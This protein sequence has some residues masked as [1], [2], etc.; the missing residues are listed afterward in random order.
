[1]YLIPAH[2]IYLKADEDEYFNPDYTEVDRVLAE[3]IA[4]AD[5]DIEGSIEYKHYLVKWCALPYEDSTW[6]LQADVNAA[7]IEAFKKFTEPP[8]D[9]ERNVSI[10]IQGMLYKFFARAISGSPIFFA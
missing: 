6:E 1:M 10:P 9:M 8:E 4:L 7:K 5:P 2:F 3:S